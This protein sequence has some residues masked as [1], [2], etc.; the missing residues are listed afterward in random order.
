MLTGLRTLVLNANYM[1]VS[2][3]PLECIPAEDAVTRIL[4]GTCHSV[5]EYDRAILTPNLKMKW[6]SVIARNSNVRAKAQTVK[7]S[8][9]TLYYRDHG[10]CAYCET[11][12]TIGTTTYDHIHP[13]S[14]GGPH[15][16]ENVVASCSAC[17]SRKG[18]HL[19]TGSWKPKHKAYKPDY[20][21]LVAARKK[22][23]IVIP[24]QEWQ[25]FLG[26]WNAEVVIG[27]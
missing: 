24:H 14:L 3:F 22:F 13:Q 10:I 4:N 1:P 18:S 9:D 26:D 20:W 16:W 27:D 15:T 11:S 2:V 12:L 6:P 25:Q 8:R 5:F 19:P 17:N 7:L 21:Q 23:P